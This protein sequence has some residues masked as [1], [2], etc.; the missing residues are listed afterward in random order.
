[1]VFLWLHSAG[2]VPVRKHIY[3]ARRLDLDFHCERRCQ[4]FVLRQTG[5]GKSRKSR[6]GDLLREVEG[7]LHAYSAEIFSWKTLNRTFAH[8]WVGQQN[9]Y[10]CPSRG[11]PVNPMLHV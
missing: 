8:R 1:M 7:N 2:S 10:S 3:S 5:M 6:R 4:R 11:L 9:D